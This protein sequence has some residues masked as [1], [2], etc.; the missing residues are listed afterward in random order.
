MPLGFM[1]CYIYEGLG[2]LRPGLS[3]KGMGGGFVGG[4]RFKSQW[5]QKIYLSKKILTRDW[6]VEL[7]WPHLFNESL[8]LSFD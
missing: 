2:P 7:Y 4:S 8:L 1:C 6:A 5:G 3:G